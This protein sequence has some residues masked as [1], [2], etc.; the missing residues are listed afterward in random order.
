MPDQTA[1]TAKQFT[2]TRV[3]DAPRAHVWRAWTDPDEAPHWFHPRGLTTPR[4]PVDFDVRPGGRYRY[5]MVTARWDGVPDRSA[6][7]AKSC[8]PSG[9]CSPGASPD[10]ADEDMPRRHRGPGR[11]RRSGEQTHLTFR[12]DGIAGAARRRQLLRRLG[13]A[14]DLFAERS[15]PGARR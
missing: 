2:I 13:E 15:A 9:S 7:T 12:L 6:R 4:E 14:L 3:L 8:R 10:D 11:A 5:T 1:T